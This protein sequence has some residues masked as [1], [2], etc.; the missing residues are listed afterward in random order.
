[1]SVGERLREAREAAGLTLEDIATSTRIPTRHLESIEA[2]DFSRLPAPTYTVGFAK[3]FDR[4]W[5]AG[6]DI[7][8]AEQDYRATVQP[9][10]GNTS[11][12]RQ[13][14]G[15]IDWRTIRFFGT[16]HFLESNFTPFVTAGL[17]WTYIDTN[18]PSGP[19]ETWCWYWYGCSTFVP[20]ETSTEFS[21]NAGLGL[22]LDVGKGV[23]RF[24]TG[25]IKTKEAVTLK[26]PTA[27]IAI[28][29]T[30]LI[31]TVRYDGSAAVAVVEGA[32]LVQACGSAP[33]LE[34]SAGSTVEIAPVCAPPTRREGYEIPNEFQ[35]SRIRD[36]QGGDNGGKQSGNNRGGKGP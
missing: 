19:P 22:R 35:D 5:A 6:I 24:V 1:M 21:Y 28:R 32:I 8:W 30:H 3:N 15:Q 17:G 10:P 12:A 18:I 34:A 27:T 33:A 36:K 11:P 25:K 13:V 23:F 29:G 4:R 14:N 9:G 26:T 7:V 2:G 20:T 16:F 31:L